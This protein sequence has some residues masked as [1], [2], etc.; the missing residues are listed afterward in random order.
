MPDAGGG[1]WAERGVSGH[2]RARNPALDGIRALAVVAIVFHHNGLS[3]ARG[4]FLGVD[5]F[6]VLSGF[7]ITTLLVGEWQRDGRIDLGAFWLRRAKRLLPAALLVLAAVGA[8]AAFAASAEE[9]TTIRRDALATL[10]T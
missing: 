1:G 5:A 3:W 8:Y 9:L 7:L 10:A 4:M 2:V 6:F